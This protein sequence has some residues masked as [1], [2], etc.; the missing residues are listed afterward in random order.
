[1]Q[2]F[3]VYK[4]SSAGTKSTKQHINEVMTR[5]SDQFI[6][7]WFVQINKPDRKKGSIKLRTY[8]LIKENF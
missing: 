8:K 4:F 7:D 6:Q 1:M 2:D 5:M 3:R